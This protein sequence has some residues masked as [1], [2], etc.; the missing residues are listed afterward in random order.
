M[1]G[2]L[3]SSSSCQVRQDLGR[4]PRLRSAA[5]D[6]PHHRGQRFPPDPVPAPL[7]ADHVPPA[8]GAGR[9][10]AGVVAVRDRAGAGD[11]DDAGR[12]LRAGDQRDQ[13][14]VHDE[15]ARRGT[16]ARA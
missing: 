5:V 13:R 10:P 9:F 11:D 1:R 15:D 8:A 6:G 4:Q 3:D 12:V 7:V 16:D 2:S 14:V